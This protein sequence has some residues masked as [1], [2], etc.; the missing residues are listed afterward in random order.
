MGDTTANNAVSS[1]TPGEPRLR[2]WPGL[3][4][5]LLMWLAM[6]GPAV[7]EM[8]PMSGFM[9]MFNAPLAAAAALALWW[10]FASRLP[11]R[12]R[13]VVLAA[14]ISLGGYA[15]LA[16]HPSFAGFGLLLYALP[17]AITAFVA[18]FA[19]TPMLSWST[20][21]LLVIWVLI[22]AWG[23]YATLRFDGITGGF[24]PELAYRWTPTAEQLALAS[25]AA[26]KPATATAA[27]LVSNQALVASA[28]DWT[29]FRGPERD[30]RLS[31]IRIATDWTAQPPKQLWKQRIGPA[32][33]SF[34]VI[35]TRLYTQEQ[36]DAE[37]MVVCYDA[38]TGS[39][40]WSHRAPSRFKDQ[41]NCSGTGPR[42]TPTF[43]E[44]K[45][46]T[47]GAT[48]RLNCLD[49]LSGK[50][51]WSRDVIA[52]AGAK[53][54]IW[55]FASSPLVAHGIVSVFAGGP[56]GKSVVG[57]RAATGELAWAAG[58]GTQSYCSPQL[59]R[60]GG[61][62]QILIT[63]E[64]GLTSFQP[65]TGEVLWHYEWV[66]M[67]DLPRVVQPAVLND[68][69]VLLGT[70]MA[71]GT[72]RLKVTHSTDGWNVKEEWTSPTFKPYYNDFVV[73]GDHLYGFDTNYFTCVRLAD[74]KKVWKERGYGSGQVLLLADQ[75]LL[76]VLAEQ[77]EVA[78][79]EANPIERKEIARFKAIE[80]KTW[81]H[82][83]VAHGR[84]FVR[85]GEEIACF[86]LNEPA[87]PKAAP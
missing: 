29:C 78:L 22:A 83:V 56:D 60:L 11:W 37:E 49:A 6:K 38:E 46:Y 19:V 63:T 15:Y 75:G 2:L 45:L 64:L 79:V 17:V 52:D 58:K 14:F 61:V 33:S 82:P 81:N 51:L 85:N 25:M 26:R 36:R 24:T 48:G 71:G 3:I 30:S 57:Y 67:K 66:P 80:G 42:A 69:D 59:S 72:Q 55:G 20:R 73:Y 4:I 31:G 39:E 21:K 68:T 12:D 62:E 87:A 40:I 65:A 74:G 23:F 47:M 44:G 77:G 84:L 13:F 28:G 50:V 35:G 86:Q 5:V 32:W 53:E 41:T 9:I 27:V 70:G 54:P 7:L 76:L 1:T 10:L 34:A 43:H 16:Y 18:W 8:E